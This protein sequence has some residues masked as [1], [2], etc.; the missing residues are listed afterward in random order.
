METIMSFTVALN[1]VIMLFLMVLVGFAARKLNIVEETFSKGLSSYLFNISLPAMILSSMN[2]PFSM[3]V[4]SECGLLILA[5]VCIMAFSAVLGRL[6]AKLMKA[7]AA[8]S[9]IF[10][11]GILMSNFGFMGYPVVEA[12]FGK[13]GIFYASVYSIPLYFVVNSYGVLLMQRGSGGGISLKSVINPPITAV[14][15]GFAMFLASIRLPHTVGMSV[16]LIGSTTTPLS[17]IFVGLILG[18]SRTAEVFRNYKVYIVSFMR[19]LLLPLCALAAL[20]LARMDLLMTGIPVLVTA[21]PVAANASILAEKYGGNTYLGAQCVFVSTL[22]SI[23]TIPI[24]AVL[25]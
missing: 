23:L 21:M 25:L 22:L 20:R 11:F 9:S 24:I 3:K 12:F 8:S 6:T 13:Q 10:E 4:L 19:L 18:S 7:D 17:M 14:I 16:N 5:G 15:I 1:Q 2:Y